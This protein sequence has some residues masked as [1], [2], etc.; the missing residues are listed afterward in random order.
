MLNIPYNTKTIILKS[1]NKNI[2]RIHSKPHMYSFPYMQKHVFNMI[3][4]DKLT[5]T[6][7]NIINPHS[8]K[9]DFNIIFSVPLNRIITY[10]DK[11]I[12]A[13]ALLLQYL[14]GARPFI[15]NFSS[16]KTFS[17][18]WFKLELTATLTDNV[19]YNFLEYYTLSFFPQIPKSS[20]VQHYTWVNS[21]SFFVVHILKELNFLK[22]VTYHSIFLKWTKNLEVYFVIKTKNRLVG[23]T[24]FNFFCNNFAIKQTKASLKYNANRNTI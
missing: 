13:A 11:Q 15:T 14:T 17:S 22:L 10:E 24:F 9:F 2:N 18:S 6:L 21:N 3:L 16:F 8:L 19:A 12:L 23:A 4:H 1:Y 20:L 7:D 5:S